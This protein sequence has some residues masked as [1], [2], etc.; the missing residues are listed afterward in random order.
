MCQLIICAISKDAPHCRDN[1]ESR[2]ST[3]WVEKAT[4]MI[5]DEEEIA[6]KACGIR[7]SVVQ[8]SNVPWGSESP[9]QQKL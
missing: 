1:P 8:I 6:L 3:N 4:F 5:H 9:K 7:R 2:V